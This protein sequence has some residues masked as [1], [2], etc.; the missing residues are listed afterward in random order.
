MILDDGG[1]LTKKSCTNT[2]KCWRIHGVTEETTACTRLLE[3][4]AKGELKIN[5]QRQRRGDQNETT[6][7]YGCQSW[8]Q[9]MPSKAAPT[10]WPASRRW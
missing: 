5:D 2:R 9:L 10:C 6:T 4:L 3:M 1:D 7:K 8:P